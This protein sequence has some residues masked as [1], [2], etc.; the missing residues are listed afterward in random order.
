MKKLLFVLTLSLWIGTLQAAISQKEAFKIA[1]KFARDTTDEIMVTNNLY[2]EGDSIAIWEGQITCPFKKAWCVFIDF[3]P[4]HDWY[5]DCAY[6]FVD[7]QNGETKQVIRHTPPIAVTKQWTRY[8]IYVLPETLQKQHKS[9]LMEHLAKQKDSTKQQEKEK[10]QVRQNI[11][12][13]NSHL[14]AIIINCN[15]DGYD[16]YERFWNDCANVYRTLREH[17][18][19]RGNIYVAMSNGGVHLNNGNIS[20]LTDTDFDEDGYDDVTHEATSIGITQLFTE[21][22]EVLT[23]HDTVFIYITGQGGIS[24]DG[25]DCSSA[26]LLQSIMWPDGYLS[27]KISLLN[28]QTLN[29]VLQRSSSDCL[30]GNI[31]KEI[32]RKNHETGPHHNYVLSSCNMFSS[33]AATNYQISEYTYHWLS[34]INQMTPDDV[35]CISDSNGDGFVTMDEV[36]D[37]IEFFDSYY[38]QESSPYCLRYDLSLN[39][40]LNNEQCVYVDLYMQ[41]NVYD[42]GTEPNTT[43]QI[44]YSSPD[45]WLED[46]TG[47]R[48]DIPISGEAYDVCV[49]VR[50]RGNTTSNGDE[51]LHVHWTKAV[52][53]GAWPTSWINGAE[54]DCNGTTVSIGGEITSQNGYVLPPIQAG[55]E[56]V[57]RIPWITPV[58]S[59]YTNCSEFA[60]NNGELWHYCLLA[61]L[62]DEH[63]S[64]G[65]ELT[66][67]PM[68]TF[69]L[70]SNNVVSRNV[71]IMSNMLENNILTSVVGV[72]AP[73]NGIFDIE[74]RLAQCSYDLNNSDVVIYLTLSDNLF[75]TWNGDGS[76]FI[77]LGNGCMLLTEE[78]AVLRNFNLDST[79]MYSVQLDVEF[80]TQPIYELIYN[81][82]LTDTIGR[83]LGGEQFQETEDS[84]ET[85]YAPRRIHTDKELPL[86]A[87]SISPNPARDIVRIL[88][89]EKAQQV[90]LFNA[91]GQ[92]V[93][94]KNNVS[95]VDV[96][97]LPNGVYM[98]QVKTETTTQKT[99]LIKNSGI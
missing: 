91:I 8:R 59:T 89:N 50:N 67:E 43:T 48:V 1:E 68:S 30:A 70:N 86:A 85:W 75:N 47:A 49:K 7:A 25:H 79:Q 73:N 65:E 14:Y 77:N 51:L 27:N 6:I 39:Q 98:M 61:R 24:L 80:N 54:C 22:N 38:S 31:S 58:N 60:E 16:F 33:V 17:N 81:L 93:M 20:S 32:Q 84:W 63:E 34:A 5:H 82:T 69:V 56:Y 57:A 78:Y 76:G 97:T 26:S 52:I 35:P 11:R 62:Y 37:Y 3:Q 15:G 4:L 2:N 40:T 74:G 9:L 96:S 95:T 45:I 12:N 46:A 18:Y 13:E 88:S 71:T 21:I 53:G 99:K 72:V 92:I 94:Q 90:I 44:S 87:I 83:A 55:G 36:Q 28:A 23:A 42:L 29:V 10:I 64:P 66:P 41:D 19:P